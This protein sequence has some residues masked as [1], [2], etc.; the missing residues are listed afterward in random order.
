MTDRAKAQEALYDRIASEY[1]A[2]IPAHVARHYLERRLRV[3]GRAVREGSI[4]NVG[5]GSGTLD[6]ALVKKGYQ[7]VGLDLSTGMLGEARRKGLKRLVRASATSPPFKTGSFKA[8]VSIVVLHHLLTEANVRAALEEMCRV[9]ASGGTLIV[10][11]HNPKNP[12]WG[13]LMKRL[14][15]DSGEERLVPLEEI[16]SCLRGKAVSLE[17]RRLGFVPD[18]APRRLLWLFAVLERAA[19]ALPIVKEFAAHNVVIARR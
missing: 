3:I 10:W 8:T 4:L 17:A 15:Q 2:A 9:T 14:P 11:D 19:E 1:D 16:L 12:Y 18:F 7:V 6:E 5:C 13:P